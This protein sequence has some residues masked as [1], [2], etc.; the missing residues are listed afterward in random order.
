[1]QVFEAIML[2]CFGISWPISIM[3]AVRTKVV[4]GKS[5]MFM[6]VVF[7][8][9]LSRIA[10]KL[11]GQL[12]WVLALYVVNALFVAVDITLYFKYLPKPTSVAGV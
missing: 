7:M 3:K 11:T 12:N 4:A 1:M 5:P 8:G 2:L 10:F 6:A 9:Y